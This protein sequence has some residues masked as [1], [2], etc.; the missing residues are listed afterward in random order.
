MTNN[1]NTHSDFWERA[2]NVLVG[3]T[4]IMCSSCQ[5]LAILGT[6]VRY[7]SWGQ[8]C[9]HTFMKSESKHLLESLLLIP[10]KQGHMM[11]ELHIEPQ[12]EQLS[13]ALSALQ[14]AFVFATYAPTPHSTSQG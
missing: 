11:F 14:A 12:T 4:E 5:N 8:R 7:L 3:F 2:K 1:T 10:D 13:T 6:Y 9:P